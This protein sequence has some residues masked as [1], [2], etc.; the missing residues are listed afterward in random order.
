M[1]HKKV[2]LFDILVIRS[3]GKYSLYVFKLPEFFFTMPAALK[4]FTSWMLA[5]GEKCKSRS[6]ED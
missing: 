6:S 3:Q 1:L 2:S 5:V 4:S